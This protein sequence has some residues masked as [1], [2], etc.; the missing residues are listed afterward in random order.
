MA[1]LKTNGSLAHNVLETLTPP[2]HTG[3]PY[4]MYCYII[5]NTMDEIQMKTV[6]KWALLKTRPER[7]KI[8]TPDQALVPLEVSSRRNL[9][10]FQ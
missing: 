6:K 10:K 1:S 3:W 7:E 5:F 9:A 8:D 4:T 2:F